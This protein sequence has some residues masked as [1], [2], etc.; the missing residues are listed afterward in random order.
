MRLINIDLFIRIRRINTETNP[1]NNEFTKYFIRDEQLEKIQ[2]KI[3]PFLM[4]F[5]LSIMYALTVTTP[6]SQIIIKCI[7]IIR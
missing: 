5:I 3:S 1:N 6:H 2:C 4:I 7:I